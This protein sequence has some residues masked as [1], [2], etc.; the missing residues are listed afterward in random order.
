MPEGP[1][2]GGNPQGYSQGRPP[3]N[4]Q[5]QFNTTTPKQD[6]VQRK[7]IAHA[8]G[9]GVAGLLAVIIAYHFPNM[10][11]TVTAAYASLVVLVI[12][13]AVA[14]MTKGE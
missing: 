4:P 5:Q 12:G 8:G 13:F 11:A 1:H 9:S 2:P 14:Y 6:G 10:P 7:V 3:Y